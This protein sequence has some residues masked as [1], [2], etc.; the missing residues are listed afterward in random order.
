M[1]SRMDRVEA[2]TTIAGAIIGAAAALGG[3]AW[4]FHH[5][6]EESRRERISGEIT[7]M[8]ALRMEIGVAHEIVREMSPTLLPTQMLEGAMASI[9]RMENDQQEAIIQYSQ[10]VLRYNG[11]VERII[12]Y[13]SG[14]RASGESPGSERP[15]KQ[16]DRVLE[17]I[18]SALQAIDSHLRSSRLILKPI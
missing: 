4:T 6:A 8:R 14:K 11:R 12:A 15:E 13:G 9:H 1:R 2:I 17:A 5:T 10:S 18:P 3:V 7:S 16:A